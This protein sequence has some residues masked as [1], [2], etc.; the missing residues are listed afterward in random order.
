M[1]T[2]KVPQDVEAEDKLIGFLSL[3]QFIFT[4]LGIGFGYLTFFFFTKIHPI[5]CIIWIPP[6]IVFFVLGLY[7]R[8]DQP[9]EVYLASA[10]RFHLK[11]HTRKW[12]QEG[13]E[14]RV[15]ITAP[16]KME[17]N[18]TKNF[19]GQ[20]A[21]SHLGNISRLMD[22]RGWTS[23]L[24][25]D[26]QNPALA[27]AAASDDRLMQ[28][29]DIPMAVPATYTP[30]P[31]DVQDEQTSRVAQDFDSKIQQ[32]DNASHQQAIKRLQNARSGED[33]SQTAPTYQAYPEM[34]QKTVRPA[35]PTPPVSNVPVTAAPSI[36]DTPQ[37]ASEP[38]TTL[39]APIAPAEPP[40]ASPAPGAP[41]KPLAQPQ[42]VDE[43]EVEINLH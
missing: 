11:P 40:A 41:T 7:Q 12:D 16:P 31:V 13:F 27:M 21:T 30:Q 43:N 23:K 6:T 17:H 4:L 24:V 8:K 18:Y 10:L 9:V 39:A 14:E 32:A 15:I 37:P 35:A 34:R 36:P 5:T 20:E 38:Q 26:W 22:S 3:K 1:A 29:Q 2:H 19:T 28:P 33:E 25:G 42:T